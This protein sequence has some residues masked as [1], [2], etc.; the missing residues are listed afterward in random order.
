MTAPKIAATT[1]R[2][3]PQVKAALM[4]VSDLQGRSMANMLE[5]L[6]R[7]HCEVEGLGWPPKG[8]S[9]KTQAAKKT[10]SRS[11]RDAKHE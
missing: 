3:K 6:I 8:A 10:R 9:I 11:A 2:F 7:Q 5:W 1:I 4:R